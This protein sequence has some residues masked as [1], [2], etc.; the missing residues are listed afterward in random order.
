[1]INKTPSG[2][3][4]E[5]EK[6]MQFNESIELPETVKTNE[7]FFVG[8]QWE[9]V[10][11]PDLDKPVFNVLKRV[12][13]YF[14][15]MLVSDNI[16]IKMSLFNRVETDS[17]KI[18]L[19]LI[20][21]QLRQVMEY[22]RFGVLMRDVL[23]DAAVDGD[24]VLHVY[25]DPA[26]KTGWDGVT[27]MIRVEQV[28]NTSIFFGNPQVADV[29]KQP[30]VIIESRRM[31]GAVKEEM[32]ANGRP[33]TEIE[34][35]QT[36]TKQEWD[37][38]EYDDKV[39]VLTKYWREN[40]KIHY[41]KTARSA[42]IKDETATTLELYPICFMNWENVKN[43]YHGQGIISGLIPN[44]MAINKMAALA[45][46]FI[47]QQAFPRI[48]YNEDKIKRWEEGVRPVAVQGDPANIVYTP[49]QPTTM[50]GQVGEYM[51]RFT[52]MTR[53]LMGASDAALGNVNPQN[54]SAIIAVQKATA[55]PLELV[56]QSYYQF[57][58]DFVRIG[59]D[60]MR[61]FY[62]TRTVVA[63]DG[64]GDP[65][66]IEFD[67]SQLA[68]YVLEYNVDIGQ[69]AYWSEMSAVQTLD[70]LL[71]RGLV[72]PVLYLESIP[73]ALVPNKSKIV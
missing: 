3:W 17:Q 23:R 48:F 14:I 31:I 27:G 40:G 9:G 69:A 61:E 11:A 33:E 43:C 21:A 68:E 19:D 63:D 36:D 42:V 4:S 6:G 34:S 67:F 62:G 70:N 59:V 25:F 56:R 15:A 44:Q 1:M 53:D 41:I 29:Q 13:N 50:S 20:E 45:Q 66:E 52:E 22:N 37:D 16:G 73:D 24:G 64:N 55:I 12:V 30:Y 57:V 54:T 39:T 72:D 5:Y 58:E 28:D 10:N 7:N 46:R 18:M 65:Q 32:R 47:R 49:N 2:I 35:L 38:R 51:E 26:V 8:K 71:D 60:Q